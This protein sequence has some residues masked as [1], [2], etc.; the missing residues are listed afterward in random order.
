MAA[1]TIT[2]RTKDNHAVHLVFNGELHKIGP[3]KA[4]KTFDVVPSGITELTIDEYDATDEIKQA[5]A[6]KAGTAKPAGKQS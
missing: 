5:D 3:G 2:I 1:I 4:E 6:E